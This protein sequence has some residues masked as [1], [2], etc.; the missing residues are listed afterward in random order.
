ADRHP[1]PSAAPILS[2]FVPYSSSSLPLVRVRGWQR[3]SAA[4]TGDGA[5]EGCGTGGRR[6]GHCARRHA[7]GAL[8]PHGL[9]LDHGSTNHRMVPALSRSSAYS[10]PQ[11]SIAR[12]PFCGFA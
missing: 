10:I 4:A 9:T 11:P 8:A 5:S 3:E 6:A 12:L 1:H 7:G 2:S